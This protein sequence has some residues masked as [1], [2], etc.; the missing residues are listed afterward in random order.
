MPFRAFQLRLAHACLALKMEGLLS[1]EPILYEDF[2]PASAGGIFRS[3]LAD[4]AQAEYLG[5]ANRQNFEAALGCAVVDPL[6]L[7]IAAEADSL[8]ASLKSLDL[9]RALPRRIEPAGS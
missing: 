8:A 5:R 1:I 9:P 4:R 6:S 7:S 3:N 2:L